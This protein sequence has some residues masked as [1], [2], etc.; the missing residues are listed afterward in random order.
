MQISWCLLYFSSLDSTVRNERQFMTRM[1][2]F[3]VIDK[4]ENFLIFNLSKN[5]NKPAHSINFADK[6]SSALNSSDLYRIS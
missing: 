3:F 5:L 2:E 4:A 6:H 1:C